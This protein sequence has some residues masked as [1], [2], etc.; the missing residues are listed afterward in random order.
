M[1]ISIKTPL[2]EPLNPIDIF[3]D[4]STPD[5]QL[6][7]MIGKIQN[8]DVQLKELQTLIPSNKST[9]SMLS[10]IRKFQ[11]QYDHL[12]DGGEYRWDRLAKRVRGDLCSEQVGRDFQRK[13]NVFNRCLK[14][15]NS[16]INQTSSSILFYPFCFV[17]IEIDSSAND[18]LIQTYEILKTMKKKLREVLEKWPNCSKAIQQF[19]QLRERFEDHYCFMRQT[20]YDWDLL[21]RQNDLSV[22]KQNPQLFN[23]AEEFFQQKFARINTFVRRMNRSLDQINGLI[24]PLR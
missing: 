18:Q 7:T 14:T 10:E 16:I 3:Q 12:Q 13:F 5:E 11:E 22:I 6:T 8:I 20:N 21:V 1:A 17:N 4:S 23:K 2:V 19:Q 15:L 24:D 9:N